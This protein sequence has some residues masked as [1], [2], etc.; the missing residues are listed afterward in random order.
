MRPHYVIGPKSMRPSY[1]ADR[2]HTG[3]HYEKFCAFWEPWSKRDWLPMHPSH[4]R[5]WLAQTAAAPAGVA[6][7]LARAARR[8]ERLVE[9]L[10]GRLLPLVCEAPLLVGAGLESPAPRGLCW[11]PTLGVPFVPST[12]LKGLMRHWATDWAEQRGDDD[13]EEIDALLGAADRRGALIIF[14]ALPATPVHL[15]IEVLTPHYDRYIQGPPGGTEPEPPAPADW[16]TPRPLEFLV[17]SQGT[18]LGAAMAVKRGFEGDRQAA[19][20]KGTAWL[21]GALTW[22]GAGAHGAIGFGRMGLA[23]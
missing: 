17:I 20:E 16:V 12:A 15:E 14:D 6:Q 9:A 18:Q 11:H 23:G 2:G 4:R 13:E 5:E 7:E 22:L 19:L 21:E 8:R 1:D 3:L 10:G